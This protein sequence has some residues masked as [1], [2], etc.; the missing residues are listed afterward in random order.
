MQKERGGIIADAAA[1]PATPTSGKAIAAKSEELR[2]LDA[3]ATV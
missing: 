2:K 3:V 1:I